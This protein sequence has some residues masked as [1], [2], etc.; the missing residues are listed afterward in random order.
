MSPATGAARAADDNVVGGDACPDWLLLLDEPS[1]ARV[2]L[3][4]PPARGTEEWFTGRAEV[5]DA[6]RTVPDDTSDSRYDLVV[7]D[8]PGAVGRNRDQLS[9]LARAC[10]PT[11]ELRLPWHPLP[12]LRRTLHE[13]GFTNVRAEL[14]VSPQRRPGPDHGLVA[15]RTAAGSP[16]RWLSGIAASLDLPAEAPGWTLEVPD[17]YP[18]RKAIARLP[19]SP[20]SGGAVV[21]LTRHPRFNPRLENE[22]AQLAAASTLGHPVTGALPSVLATGPLAGLTVVAQ[23]AVPGRPFLD[24]SSLHHSCPLAGAVARWTSDLAVASTRPLHGA[25]LADRLG[26]LLDRFVHRFAPAPDVAGFLGE[27]VDRIGA[28]GT[29]PG[30]LFHGDLGTWNLLA[31]RGR[32]RVLDWESAEWPGPPLWDLFYFV[33]SFAVRSGRRRGLRRNRAVRRHLVVGSGFTPVAAGWVRSYT[34][35]LGSDPELTAPLFHTCWMHRAVK[36]STRLPPDQ[37]GHYGP[38]CIRLVR[39]RGTAGL[40]ELL[41]GGDPR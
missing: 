36:E 26:E 35:R 29:L 12:R 15:G 18:S 21:K 11:G 24:V 23:T 13:I 32:I 30:V 17:S 39:S 1:P 3:V 25:E 37:T 34:D 10:S 5:L 38:L 9:R 16:P 27:Q 14:D 28:A 19:G 20:P 4:G 40:R 33:R 8:D 6:R 41:G 2:L 31:D 22:A 7:V